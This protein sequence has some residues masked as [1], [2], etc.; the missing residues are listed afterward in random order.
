MMTTKNTKVIRRQFTDEQRLAAVRH[1]R[2]Q[3]TRG[4]RTWRS[5]AEELGIHESIL[6]RWCEMYPEDTKPEF[7]EVEITTRQ[8][9]RPVLTAPRGIRVEGLSVEE[10]AIL[11]K[12]IAR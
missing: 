6:R 4:G 11:L 5:V 12:T 8:E 10:I 9:S 1:M 7:R 3:C 2:E